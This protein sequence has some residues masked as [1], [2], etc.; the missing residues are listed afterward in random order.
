MEG[1]KRVSGRLR[2]VARTPDPSAADP[3]A[4]DPAAR[5]PA[6]RNPA[7]G[8]PTTGDPAATLVISAEPGLLTLE[9]TT[10]PIAQVRDLDGLKRV[11]FDLRKGQHP[12]RWVII[13]SISEVAE[14]CLATEKK[15]SKDPRAAYGEMA[16]TM[17]DLIKGF[18]DLPYNVVMLCKMT[19][20]DDDG[21]LHYLPKAPG[22]QIG[23]ELP[24][25]F[26]IVLALRA[27]RGPEG[28]VRYVQ[29]ARDH[30]Y[31]AKDRS[32]KLAFTEPPDLDYLEAKI[33]APRQEQSNAV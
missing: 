7:A 29:T 11:Y 18:R 15:K 12:F 9:G 20:V 14:I 5:N 6:A 28:L 1:A 21:R 13:D 23:P 10:I 25:L 19:S 30:Q 17:L 27:D 2:L 3:S 32:S 16:D 22:R 4:S 8:N 26:D 24:Y 33:H 31:E